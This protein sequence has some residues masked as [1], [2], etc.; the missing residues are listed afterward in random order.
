MNKWTEIVMTMDEFRKLAKTLPSLVGNLWL[1]IVMNDWNLD[2][3][4]LGKWQ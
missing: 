3:K 2:E 4:L 1:N